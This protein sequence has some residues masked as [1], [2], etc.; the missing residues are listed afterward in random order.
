MLTQ[1]VKLKYP[2]VYS[3]NRVPVDLVL[4]SIVNILTYV[5]GITRLIITLRILAKK[6][7]FF[8]I[9]IVHIYDKTT[10]CECHHIEYEH[11]PLK[12][13][14]KFQLFLAYQIPLQQLTLHL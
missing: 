9:V 1:D 3:I 8:N 5:C 6:V 7:R 14:Y 2:I 12:F 11:K 10:R 4:E 13:A